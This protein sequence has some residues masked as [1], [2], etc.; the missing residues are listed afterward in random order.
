MESYPDFIRL[1]E[2]FNEHDVEYMIVGGYAL[3]FY[4]APRYTGDIDVLVR[5]E[6]R[7]ARHI[8]AALDEF[9]FG[10]V[11]LESADFENPNQV[12]QL[13]R[14]PVRVDLIT[15]IS[16]LTWEEAVSGIVN[17]RYGN[18]PVRFIGLEQ[19]IANKR[20]CAR[21]KDLADLEALGAG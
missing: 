15:S 3:A 8:L 4:G 20:A 10:S 9:G 14:P 16:G 13:G 6:R 7:N 21:K 2:L 18:V 17:G 19:F 12:I 5:P 11:G 1:F